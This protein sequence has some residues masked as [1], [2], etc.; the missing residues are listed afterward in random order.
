MSKKAS[1]L[2]PVART[3]DAELAKA[4][5]LPVSSPET[6]FLRAWFEYDSGLGNPEHRHRWGTLL[7]VVMVVG[8]SGGFWTGVGL[9]IARLLR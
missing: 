1:K 9:L 5:P 8:I 7:G 4:P 6:N 2:F 3:N